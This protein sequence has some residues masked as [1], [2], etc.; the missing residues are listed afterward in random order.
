[1]REGWR[2]LPRRGGVR[3]RGEGAEQLLAWCCMACGDCGT[4]TG[5]W[6]P[7]GRPGKRWMRQAA[8]GEAGARTAGGVACAPARPVPPRPAPPRPA[9]LRGGL[10]HHGGDDAHGHALVAARD[11]QETSAAQVLVGRLAV[12]L[13]VEQA[14]YQQRPIHA[15]H[16]QDAVGHLT[17]LHGRGARR[18]R[19]M[20]WQGRAARR[21]PL[22]E[23]LGGCLGAQAPAMHTQLPGSKHP[24][25]R[26]GDAT[27]W[28][29]GAW[30]R[31]LRRL[32]CWR[33]TAP[34]ACG[35]RR[36]AVVALAPGGGA[37]ARAESRA[38]RLTHP[39]WDGPP[40]PSMRC[41]SED[42]A[43][44]GSAN[45]HQCGGRDLSPGRY[46]RLRAQGNAGGAT[47]VLNR[48]SLPL[49]LRLL[50]CATCRQRVLPWSP[51]RP[52]TA[53][54]C[55]W[56]AMLHLYPQPRVCWVTHTV[57][58]SGRGGGGPAQPSPLSQ[59]GAAATQRGSLAR[60]H[61][62]QASQRACVRPS[63]GTG[64]CCRQERGHCLPWCKRC[65]P[66]PP[67]LPHFHPP[68]TQRSGPPL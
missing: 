44:T 67:L 15:A 17:T 55:C 7:G 21:R 5:T 40:V 1:L 41:A 57:W 12:R 30:W 9:Q 24:G 45:L 36:R 26:A 62:L 37:E 52:G 19:H 47:H 34:G 50:G 46:R 11:R 22:G 8:P 38:M 63:A 66:L 13:W 33:P 61:A 64:H 35:R 23:R 29:P 58:R 3:P 68:C 16:R 25:A 54:L 2:G 10:T 56:S 31:H 60:E 28:C 65:P 43:S 39:L 20:G 53:L 27:P 51:V 59:R 18:P 4:H 48:N 6:R 49:P 32:A 14:R 42:T